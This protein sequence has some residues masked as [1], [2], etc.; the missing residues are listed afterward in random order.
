MDIETLMTLTEAADRMGV[1]FSL[2]RAFL[3]SSG[4][5]YRRI[6]KTIAIDADGFAELKRVIEAWR[7]RPLPYSRKA[8]ST[9][10]AR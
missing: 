6:G 4:I 9:G 10:A 3:D 5:E 8:S 2:V 1:P 7:S